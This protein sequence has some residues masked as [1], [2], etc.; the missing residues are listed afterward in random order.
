MVPELGPCIFNILS[1]LRAL[2]HHSDYC[3]RVVNISDVF[4]HSPCISLVHSILSAVPLLQMLLVS[5]DR[6]TP[7]ECSMSEGS[8]GLL[9]EDFPGKRQPS[10]NFTLQRVICLFVCMWLN[11]KFPL[12]RHLPM[13]IWNNEFAG[14]ASICCTV[15]LHL[16]PSFGSFLLRHQPLSFLKICRSGK[17]QKQK[18]IMQGSCSRE[19]EIAT[20]SAAKRLLLLFTWLFHGL[21]GSHTDVTLCSDLSWETYIR[22]W[23]LGNKEFLLLSLSFSNFTTLVETF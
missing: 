10:S 21:N 7:M 23:L 20:A 4:S 19:R 2:S 18:N 16:L 8:L 12:Y 15:L 14:Q 22:I 6:K 13:G 11:L 5:F 3:L 1:G 17:P 9:E